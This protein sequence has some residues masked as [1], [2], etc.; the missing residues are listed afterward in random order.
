VTANESEV[1]TL[2]T[3]LAEAFADRPVPAVDVALTYGDPRY[4]DEEG[5]RLG[6]FLRGRD[7]RTLDAAVLA[8]DYPGDARV[9]PLFLRPE[10]FAY[11]LPAF[12]RLAIE[13]VAEDDWEMADGL[14]FA[15]TPDRSDGEQEAFFA[16]RVSDLRP[17]ERA[18]VRRVL[19]HLAAAYERA[20]NERN[21]ARR[22]L[23]AY[24]ECPG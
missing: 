23:S 2:R 17:G 10:A 9:V 12:L 21:P 15:L 14:T 6:R 11:F 5:Q 8:N 22:A 3:A 7:W 24:W 1:A 19:E 18:M 20:G 16:E 13:G 4:V